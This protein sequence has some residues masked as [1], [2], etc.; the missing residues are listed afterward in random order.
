M[1][2]FI[3]RKKSLETLSSPEQLDRVMEVTRPLGWI[4]LLGCFC[5]ICIAV[6]WGL[7][8]QIHTITLGEGILLRDGAIYDVVSLGTGQVASVHVEAGDEI[9]QGQVVA[10]LSLPDL[11]HQLKEARDRLVSLES[12]RQMILNLGD[13]TNL[14]KR[15]TLANER[16][17]LEKA[18]AG[19]KE[20]L[21]FLEKEL[22]HVQ[23]LFSKELT[24]RNEVQTVKNRYKKSMQNILEYQSRL[25][26]ISARDMDLSAVT[27]K[28]RF[29]I[30]HRISLARLKIRALEEN[31]NLQSRIVSSRAG[32]V[33]EVYKNSGKVIRTG[34]PMLSI[35]V[36]G[37]ARDKLS[38]FLYFS[39]RD[40]KKVKTGMTV[41]ISP[42]TV[43]ME[44]D[45]YMLGQVR[46]VSG[47]PASRKGMLKVLQ[48]Q[49]LVTSLSAGGAPI[50]VT[51]ELMEDK[52]SPSRYQWSS[53][54]GP[55]IGIESGTLCRANVV[56]ESDAP[57]RLALP[58]LKKKILGIG[59]ELVKRGKK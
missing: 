20:N 2:N 41:R 12:E 4:S 47:F 23:D 40:G 30:E 1:V 25:N 26:D 38:A 58:F 49:D 37:G 19:E 57:I 35:E 17:T 48:N 32:R 45:G 8:G 53:G 18:I 51:A 7:Y 52:S 3:F 42:S 50:A 28:E 31:R 36:A 34:E 54:K 55:D 44:E 22:A 11:D 29:A 6:L 5:L 46:Q 10:G 59:D 24:T 56:V 33:L 43:K 9:E 15:K 39:P 21:S 27:R 14:L 13:K 16:R